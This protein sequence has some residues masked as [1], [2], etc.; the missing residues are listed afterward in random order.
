MP[1]MPQ[2]SD[3]PILLADILTDIFVGAGD[4]AVAPKFKLCLQKLGVLWMRETE[5]YFYMCLLACHVSLSCRPLAISHFSGRVL[6]L[7]VSQQ[8]A[9]LLCDFLGIIG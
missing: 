6:C 2:R 7:H 4:F 9:C 8:I 3:L 1:N 5:R